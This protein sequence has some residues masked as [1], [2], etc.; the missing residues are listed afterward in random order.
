M[1]CDSLVGEPENAHRSQVENKQQDAGLEQ[2]VI[3][4]LSS[5]DIVGTES[6][7]RFKGKLGKHRAEKG[8]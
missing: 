5:K 1:L 2:Q 4:V 3:D 7:H 8:T 6:F